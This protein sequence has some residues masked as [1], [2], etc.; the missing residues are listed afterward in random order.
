MPGPGEKEMEIY[1]FMDIEFQSY[2]MKR[3][4]EMDGSDGY[5]TILIHLITLNCTVKNGEYGKKNTVLKSSFIL[6]YIS[7]VDIHL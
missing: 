4:L 3:I 7:N 2:K 1:W 6:W 5:T